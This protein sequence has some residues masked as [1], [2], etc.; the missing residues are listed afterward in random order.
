MP[1]FNGGKYL[2]QTLDS[3]I[4][5][6]FTDWEIIFMDGGSKDDT[7]AIARGYVEKYPNIYITS[8][9]D[10]GP[11]H[12]IHKA[13]AIAK[14]EYVLVLCASDGYLEVRW[15]EL[16]AEALDNDKELSVV[17]GIPFDI[18]EEGQLK[19]PHFMYAHF[20]KGSNARRPFFRELG[21]RL[22]SP[23]SLLRLLKKFN[24]SH[25]ATVKNVIVGVKPPEKEAWF[26]Y[27]LHTG[28]IFPDGNMCLPRKV[29][30]DCLPPYKA[31]TREVGDWMQLFFNINARGYFSRCIPVAANFT[32]NDHVGSVTKRAQDYND[33]TRRRYFAKLAE[34]CAEINAFP[35]VM[36]FRDRDKKP[37]A[38]IKLSSVR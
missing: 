16:C 7:I 21:R 26:K 34:F 33:M 31:G 35:E 30:L 24:A 8:E 9:P 1:V 25:L 19:G 4:A 23:S 3:V 28:T 37:I 18:T 36:V 12:A 38:R 13:L 20:L 11:Y 10:E 15:L 27:W 17:W 29:L 22:T 32:R 6:T 14:G 2:K 5:Q